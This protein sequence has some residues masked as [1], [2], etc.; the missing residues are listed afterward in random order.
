M[1]CETVGKVY[2]V[3]RG[4]VKM[5]SNPREKD[6]AGP[7]GAPVL[8]HLTK[9]KAELLV[10]F[11]AG[12]DASYCGLVSSMLGKMVMTSYSDVGYQTRFVKPKH[13]PLYR[14]KYSNNDIYLTV[15]ELGDEPSF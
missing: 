9:G 6:Q 1:I 5:L 12:G 10:S 13:F 14:Y 8:Y 4:P 11:P 3:G 2:L 15:I 7:N